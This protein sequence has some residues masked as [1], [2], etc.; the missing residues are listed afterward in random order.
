MYT[1]FHDS[2][3]YSQSLSL[4]QCGHPQPTFLL[5]PNKLCAAGKSLT[6]TN[7]MTLS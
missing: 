6:V 2:L 7:K 5:C 1:V 4:K 3:K